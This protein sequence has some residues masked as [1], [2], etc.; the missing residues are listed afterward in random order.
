[1]SSEERRGYATHLTE[2][3]LKQAK[4]ESGFTSRTSFR[5][6]VLIGLRSIAI[7]SAIFFYFVSILQIQ[8]HFVGYGFVSIGLGT[9]FLALALGPKISKIIRKR[10]S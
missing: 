9:L 2:H 1:M 5:S 7:L 8:D 3:I 6:V 4:D 10:I